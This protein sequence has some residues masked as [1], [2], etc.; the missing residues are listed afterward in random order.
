MNR[1]KNEKRHITIGVSNIKEIKE[2]IKA[3]LGWYILK[4]KIK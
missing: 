4:L 2:G 3:T 1:N